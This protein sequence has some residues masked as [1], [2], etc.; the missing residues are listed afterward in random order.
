[1]T[2]TVNESA[3][4]PFA[5]RAKHFVSVLAT[6]IATLA[7]PPVTRLPKA[8]FIEERQRLRVGAIAAILAVLAS[9]GWIDAAAFRAAGQLPSWLNETYNVIT[10]YGRSGWVLWPAGILLL[11]TA[12]A[13][14]IA[15]ARMTQ[16]VLATVAVRLGFV[17]LAVGIPGLLDNIG[18][19][20]IGRV[21]PSAFGPFAYHPFSWDSAYASFPSGHTAAAFSALVAIGALFPR[22]R[23]LLWIYAITIAM[24]RVIIAAHYPSDVIAG[25][26]V[27]AFG[28]ILVR[29]WFAAR[30]LGFYV[31][32]DGGAHAMPGPSF[33][34]IKRVARTLA[35]Q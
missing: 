26:A 9:M 19:R 10:D 7:R 18:K 27:G 29:E 22:L 3:L 17:F 16:L 28:A 6:W 33:K 5:A 25:A 32:G 1:M 30:R 8:A 35:A 31:G 34:R 23:P 14:T 11:A 2:V 15:T 13:T 20:M 24:S 4:Q 21:R 12:A